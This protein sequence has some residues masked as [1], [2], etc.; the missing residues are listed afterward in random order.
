MGVGQKLFPIDHPGVTE[1]LS[2]LE[3]VRRSRLTLVATVGA[4]ACITVMVSEVI[5]A[6]AGFFPSLDPP[7]LE[8][9]AMTFHIASFVIAAILF[10]IPTLHTQTILVL[11]L[12]LF[13]SNI[14]VRSFA[15]IAIVETGDHFP[16]I[17][18]ILLA[19]V[20]HGVLVP[21]RLTFAIA[22][23]LI[24]VLS[25]PLF[26]TIGYFYFETVRSHWDQ[27][28]PSTF[29]FLV[30]LNTLSISIFAFL[31]ILSSKIFYGLSKQAEL[32]KRLGNY[33]I[34]RELTAGGMGVVF[35]ARHRLLKRKTA[36]KVLRKEQIGGED[37]LRRF[38]REVELAASL[39]HPN[40]IS[41]FDF[42]TTSNGTFYYVMELLEGLDL[43]ELI[44][45][46]GPIPT[47]RAIHLLLQVCGS[48]SEA[49]T[50][51][52]VHRD[53]KPANI[54][55]T[56]RGG[57]YDF[58]KVI[59]F[60]LA[61]KTDHVGKDDLRLTKTGQLFG[62][63]AYLAPEGAYGSDQLDHRS[64]IYSLGAVAYWLMTG[65]PVFEG[66]VMKVIM[67]HV[68]CEPVPPSKVSE[69]EVPQEMDKIILKCLAKK[70]ED[71]FSSILELAQKLTELGVTYTWSN[72]K[73]KDWWL[74]HYAND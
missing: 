37:V 26:Q 23:G 8:Q 3:H 41:I 56:I 30:T 59:D 55:L 28:K 33:E 74:D 1:L 68:S 34:D 25:F 44:H 64:D 48:L 24:G 73:A 2:E 65:K 67:D 6:G 62:T 20:L 60:G 71:R 15:T 5:F 13:A 21:T 27:L 51:G 49:H 47:S 22:L 63:P 54:F 52:I 18:G 40:S 39:T 53:I 12:L 7:F 69:L 32:G 10:R 61:K 36:I 19:L 16:G 42:G 14:I 57:L 29:P 35:A 45:Q 9:L 4:F 31:G 66:E 17:E 46:H 43:N 72:D 58:V 50:K 38:E 70:K 11:D